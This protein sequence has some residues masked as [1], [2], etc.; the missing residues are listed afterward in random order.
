MEFCLNDVNDNPKCPHCGEEIIDWAE[1]RGFNG[2]GA[3]IE[4]E[5]GKCDKNFIAT[6]IVS[7][8]LQ[9]LKFRLVGFAK[10]LYLSVGARQ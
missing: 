6:M 10:H 2:D 1:Y 9:S 5:C 4:V 3:E 8:S 7:I